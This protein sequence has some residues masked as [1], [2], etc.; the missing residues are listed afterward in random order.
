MG[1]I[2]IHDLAYRLQADWARLIED[3]GRRGANAHL[4]RY[5]D[6]VSRPQHMLQKILVHAGLAATNELVEDCVRTGF[7]DTIASLGHRTISLEQSV[8]RWRRELDGHTQELADNLFADAI[9]TF[10]YA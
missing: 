4:V 7:N 8:G 10:G 1:D 2:S 9:N 3:Y 6:L 5:E